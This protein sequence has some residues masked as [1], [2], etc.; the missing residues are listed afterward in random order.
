MYTHPTRICRP[1]RRRVG[2]TLVEV[3]IALSITAA[4]LTAVGMA[5]DA[6]VQGYQVNQAESTLAQRARLTLHRMLTNIRAGDGHQAYAAAAQTDFAKGLVVADTGIAFYSDDGH[7]TLYRYDAANKRLMADVDGA[8]HV[9]LD[10]VDAF[11]L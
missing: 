3:L 7:A 6:S 2:A 10:G 4:L 5:L 11:S 8:S 9:L 1:D